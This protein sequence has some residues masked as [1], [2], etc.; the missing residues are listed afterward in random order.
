[1]EGGKLLYF[2]Q[3][4]KH[5]YSFW[6]QLYLLCCAA[7][8]LEGEIVED[9]DGSLR[10]EWVEFNRSTSEIR[11]ELACSSTKRKGIRNGVSD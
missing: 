9:V 7:G 2:A 10:G 8:G 11:I 4:L 6:Q 1:M 3:L 5:F